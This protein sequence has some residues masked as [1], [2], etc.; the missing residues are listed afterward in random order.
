VDA[1]NLF[2]MLNNLVFALRACHDPRHATAVPEEPGR[3][4]DFVWFRSAGIGRFRRSDYVAYVGASKGGIIK[5]FDRRTCR[6]VYSDCGYIGQQRNRKRVT[7][8]HFD[9]ARP[10]E[11]APHKL[12]LASSFVRV[13]RPAMRPWLFLGFRVFSLTLGRSAA[14]ARWLKQCLVNVLIY[15]K[16]PIGIELRR[17][18]EF[19]DR[20]VTV[21]DQ[22][23]GAGLANLEEI[24]WAPAFTTIHMGSSRYFVEHELN[25]IGFDAEQSERLDAHRISEH[26]VLTRTIRFD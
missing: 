15:R 21:L 5:L 25:D 9:P 13:S 1:Y 14:L 23:G 6:L 24:R 4:D 10:V 16:Q 8:Q 3:E 19:H 18:I 22:L 11:V 7:S 26:P 17:M 12:T 2:P 20:H